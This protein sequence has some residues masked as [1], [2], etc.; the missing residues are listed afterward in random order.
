MQR[1]GNEHPPP[2]AVAIGDE[3]NERFIVWQSCRNLRAVHVGGREHIDE[4]LMFIDVVAQAPRDEIRQ[5][6]ADG[7]VTA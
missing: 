6:D 3:P 7:G 1:V 2:G 4:R 5:T